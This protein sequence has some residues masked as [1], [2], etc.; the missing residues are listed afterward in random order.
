MWGI[1]V[2]DTSDFLQADDIQKVIKVPHA[3][4][5]GNHTDEQIESFISVNS[6]GRQGRYYRLAA[7][8]LGLVKLTG[9]NHTEL[10]ELGL[11]FV[12]EKS[13]GQEDIIKAEIRKLPVFSQAISF[14]S[15]ESPSEAEKKEWFIKNYPGGQATA[16]RRFSTFIK[17]LQYSYR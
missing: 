2:M 1:E 3:V 10:T 15:K 7:Q 12:K 16:E 5:A 8:K 6:Q 17:Y 13:D 14:I 11:Q 9:N 4:E